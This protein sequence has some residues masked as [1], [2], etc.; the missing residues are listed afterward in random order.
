MIKKKS[1]IYVNYCRFSDCFL[2]P[3]HSDCWCLICITRKRHPVL[4]IRYFDFC[5]CTEYRSFL[6]SFFFALSQQHLPIKNTLRRCINPSGDISGPIAIGFIHL[7]PVS[8]K[9]NVS[10]L[11]AMKNRHKVANSSKNHLITLSF[12]PFTDIFSEK[13]FHRNQLIFTG[14]TA[15]IDSQHV[16]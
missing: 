4:K 13:D 6:P 14:N 7:Q 10:L 11:C 15:S 5:H 8:I 3:F 9:A 1:N 16:Y 2:K 12:L